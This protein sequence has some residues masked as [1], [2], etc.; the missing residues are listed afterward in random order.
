MGKQRA[1]TLCGCLATAL[2]LLIGCANGGGGSPQAYAAP[3]PVAAPP[4]YA[5]GP[6]IY[7]VGPPAPAAI[8][9]MLPGPGDMLTADPGLWTAQ[10]FDVV[11][12]APSEINRIAADQQ[13]AMARLVAR[14]QAV[15]NAPVWLIG[16]NPSIEAAMAS[17]PA[18]GPGRVSGVVVTSMSSGAATCSEQMTYSYPGNGA[19]PKVSVSRSGNAC[20]P[21]P[22]FGAGPNPTLAPPPAAAP[23]N[24]PRLIEAAAPAGSPAPAARVRQIADLIKS[25]PPS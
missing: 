22:S 24:A 10:G 13:A 20:P 2:P 15:A 5:D 16:P 14:A 8:L 17:L 21:G 9:V 18:G 3:P 1:A 7:A 19:A 12:P 25:A 11:T 4:A 6:Q 23:P